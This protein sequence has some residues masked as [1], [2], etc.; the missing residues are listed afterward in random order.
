MLK[1]TLGLLVIEVKTKPP[2]PNSLLSQLQRYEQWAEGQ[3]AAG[4]PQ[5]HAE[6]Q[7]TTLR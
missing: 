2:D 5:S 1:G 3:R 7:V 4:N 6:C